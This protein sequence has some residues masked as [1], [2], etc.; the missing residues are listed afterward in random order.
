LG[1]PDKPPSR[2]PEVGFF[3]EEDTN[4]IIRKVADAKHLTIF[5]GAG[6]AADLEIPNWS[7][8]VARLLEGLEL[9]EDDGEG[10]CRKAVGFALDF[11]HQM[12]TASIVDALYEERYPGEAVQRR[13]EDIAQI[14]YFDNGRSAKP[15]VPNDALAIYVLRLAATKWLAGC[16]VHIVTTNYDDSL[17]WI[18]ANNPDVLSDVGK[19]GVR[20]FS[21]T[22]YTD[23]RRDNGVPV[24]HVHGLIP[25]TG[26]GRDVVF[27]ESD[28]IEWDEGSK[29]RAYLT[30]R[31][32]G[33]GVTLFVGASLRDYNIAALI[34]RYSRGD[35]YA[36]LPVEDEVAHSTKSKNPWPTT[37]ARYATLRG[38]HLGLE[39]LRPDFYGQVCQFLNEAAIQAGVDVPDYSKRL[40]RWWQAWLGDQ[41]YER[42]LLE[43]R[44]ELLR[45]FSTR[46]HERLPNVEHVK[47][48]IWV[49]AEPDAR[50]L[51]LYSTSQTVVM[52]GDGYWPHASKIEHLSRYAA[53]S[54]LA[55]RRATQRR[56]DYRNDNRW[57]HCL[58][59]PLILLES[60]HYELPV[61]VM[62]LLLHAPEVEREK[63]FG[64][65]QREHMYDLAIRMK[66]IGQDF[67]RP[68]ISSP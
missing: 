54:A 67:L 51:Q 60:P 22:D 13:N 26:A 28:Y 24:S 36:L 25:R 27:S 17:E 57:T 68:G 63:Y 53:V 23:G 49:R 64:E 40:R 59:V 16:D 48:E 44:C 10:S 50:E 14:L 4:S 8:L 55:A 58:A 33:G 35:V 42:R 30:K 31:L 1:N 6:I 11:F 12:P 15:H 34:K 2:N 7:G 3:D 46:E 39:V 18:A 21:N 29:W 66:E 19:H 5:V 62:V 52:P 56:V 32:A 9:S 65:A 43:Q 61:G 45:R 41:P 37:S 20:V 38:L 47:A